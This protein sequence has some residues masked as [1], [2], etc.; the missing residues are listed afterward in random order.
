MKNV[1]LLFAAMA[2]TFL[3]TSC[4]ED[5]LTDQVAPNNASEQSDVQGASAEC[6]TLDLFQETEFEFDISEAKGVTVDFSRPGALR[7]QGNQDGADATLGPVATTLDVIYQ[8]F[9][10]D[11][12]GTATII[13]EAT[14]DQLD[15]RLAG[16][17]VAV[18]KNTLEIPIIGVRGTGEYRP[19]NTATGTLTIELNVPLEEALGVVRG[20]L[21]IEATLDCTADDHF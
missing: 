19:Y 15:L 6:K 20:I 3:F 17:Q 1:S 8:F 7:I 12:R 16:R 2:F 5:N 13:E 4:A 9:T 10:D 18:G 14:R 21:T 11:A